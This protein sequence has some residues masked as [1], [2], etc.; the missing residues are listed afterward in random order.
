M[1]TAAVERRVDVLVRR[2][3]A[4]LDTVAFRKELL[5]CLRR[6]VPVDAAFFATVDP[7]TVLFTSVFVE[8]PLGVASA[9]FMENEF[10]DDDVNKFAALARSDDPV[11]TLDRATKGDRRSSARYAGIMAPLDLGDEMRAALSSRGRC[12]GVMCLHRQDVQ[13]GFTP[14]EVNLVRRLVPHIGEGLR[15]ALLVDARTRPGAAGEGPGVLL[16]DE[17]LSVSSM[18]PEAERWLAELGAG[19]TPL[20]ADLPPPVY[21]AARAAL[22]PTSSNGGPSPTIRLR[23]QRGE[24]VTLYAS[25]MYGPNG[26]HTSVVLESARPLQLASLLLDAHGLTPA[27]SRVA[28]LVLQGRSTRQIVNELR[29]SAHTV[30]E[31]LGAVFDKFGIGSRRELVAALLGGPP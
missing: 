14:E 15:R 12:W 16:L 27:Q 31:H 9:L 3:Y 28:A 8:D 17:D 24:W 6:V 23:T 10:G 26:G 19:Q 11:S 1:T 30:Q 21:A 4:G 5:E 29:I 18:N 7:G 22:G 25:S 20:G 2:C 13:A